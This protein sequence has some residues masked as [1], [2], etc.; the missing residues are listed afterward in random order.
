VTSADLR[1]VF[2]IITDCDTSA[3]WI[4]TGFYFPKLSIWYF[5]MLNKFTF[6]INKKITKKE[7]DEL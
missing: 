4:K 6:S 3:L 2:C 7:E 5:S 1:E